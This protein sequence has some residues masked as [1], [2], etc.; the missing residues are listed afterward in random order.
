MVY[1]L[2]AFVHWKRTKEEKEEEA[3]GGL[4]RRG[5]RVAV[6]MGDQ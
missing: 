2:L 4:V 3:A 1:Y 5:G 6:K